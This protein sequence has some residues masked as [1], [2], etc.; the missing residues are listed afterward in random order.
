MNKTAR[1]TFKTKPE[2]I[3]KIFRNEISCLLDKSNNAMTSLHPLIQHDSSRFKDKLYGI[4]VP[5]ESIFGTYLKKINLVH[6]TYDKF[7]F[8]RLDDIMPKNEK[9]NHFH[10]VACKLNPDATVNLVANLLEKYLNGVKPVCFM[11]D[12]ETKEIL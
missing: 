4:L 7:H 2:D 3:L 9:Y 11:V 6:K 12:A 1:F 5:R 8:V 10:E